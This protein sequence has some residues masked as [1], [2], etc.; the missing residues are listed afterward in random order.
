M[1]EYPMNEFEL[2]YALQRFT[3]IT[4]S[5]LS[6]NDEFWTEGELQEAIKQGDSEVGQA[7]EQ[8]KTSYS[9]WA[10]T[11]ARNPDC[12]AIGEAKDSARQQLIQTLSRKYPPDR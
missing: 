2:A 11:S 3:S 7:L 10:R 8:F 6:I 9:V 12:I 1:S 5:R 4:A